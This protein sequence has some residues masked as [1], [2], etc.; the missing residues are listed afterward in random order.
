MTPAVSAQSTEEERMDDLRGQ[1][2]A[3]STYITRTFIK[4]YATPLA[5]EALRDIIRESDAWFENVQEESGHFRYE[6]VPYRKELL[7]DDNIVRQAGALYALGEIARR[8]SSNSIDNDATIEN[9]IA[10]FESVS[11]KDTFEGVSFRCIA[12]NRSSTLCQLGATSLA[13]AGILGYLEKHPEKRGQYEVLVEDYASFILAMKMPDRGFRQQYRVEGRSQVETESPYFNGES[14]M[15]LVHYYEFN[16]REDVREVVGDTFEHLREAPFDG[17]LYLWIMAALK[18]MEELWPNTEYVSYAKAFTDWRIAEVRPFRGTDR[19]YCAFTEG[20]ASAYSVLRD[21]LDENERVSLISELDYWLN[22]DAALE[23]KEADRYRIVAENGAP[24]FGILEE[25]RFAVGGFLTAE[26]E[27][28]LRIDFTQHC[29]G[30][31]LQV[32][33]DVRG[34]HL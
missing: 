20:L 16:P 4:P 32:L 7:E 23:I 5:D 34:G 13:L 2:Y 14:L 25:P 30:A 9:A 31:Y 33:V 8:D 6:Y 29:I 24:T 3:L 21:H 18:G 15:T 10:Y 1:L 22:K 12:A 27:P 26:D 28:T 11:R 17:A 19:N